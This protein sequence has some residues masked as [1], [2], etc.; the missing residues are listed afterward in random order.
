MQMKQPTAGRMK[1]T[2]V[3]RPIQLCVAT[4]VLMATASVQAAMIAQWNFDIPDGS[5]YGDT[6]TST[7]DTANSL[8]ANYADNGGAGA[9]VFYASPATGLTGASADI[10]GGGGLEVADDQ[11]LTGYDG[12][13]SGFTAFS[14]DAHVRFR[15]L[16]TAENVIVRKIGGGTDNDP[17]YQ[18]Y[19]KDNGSLGFRLNDWNFFSTAG[20]ATSAAGAISLSTW[21][22]VTGSWDGTEIKVYVDGV[23]AGSTAWTAGHGTPGVLDFD[24][25]G[26]LGIGGYRNQA[27]EVSQYIN[28]QIDDVSIYNEAI[29]EPST[30]SMIALSGLALM[31]FRRMAL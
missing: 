17:G 28:G 2:T 9:D 23:E 25:T 15:S 20:I 8:V 14:I 19:V 24:T 16:A 18:F 30:L 29:P 31:G 5:S 10:R 11:I 22:H 6:I 12:G 27:G 1:N 13:G 26:S 3:Y 21:Y 7:T 4:F